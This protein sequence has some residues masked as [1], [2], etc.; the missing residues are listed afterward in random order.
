MKEIAEQTGNREEAEK[1]RSELEELEEKA[2]HLDK[3]RSKNLSAI[4]YEMLEI[5]FSMSCLLV[6][7]LFDF[8]VVLFVMFNCIEFKFKYSVIFFPYGASLKVTQME[9]NMVKNSNWLEA[10]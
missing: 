1:L 7:S 5:P 10:N 3:V 4:R 6:E 2:S 8:W 9:R